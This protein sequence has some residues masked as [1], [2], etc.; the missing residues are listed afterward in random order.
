[1]PRPAYVMFANSGANDQVSNLVSLFD[2]IEIVN[3][4]Q[5]NA[6]IQMPQ[7]GTTMLN[8]IV[9]AWLRLDGD[10][11]ADRFEGQI[12]V[13]NP[14]GTDLFVVPTEAFSFTS[15]FFRWTAPVMPFGFSALGLHQIEARLRRVGQQ[16]WLCRQTFPFIVQAMPMPVV[17]VIPTPT[18]PLEPPAG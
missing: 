10:S 16:E 5:P 8:R 6:P 7:V 11:D 18:P 2:V 12:A 4:F 9:V 15:P 3:V 17:P 14:D 13:V 1:M